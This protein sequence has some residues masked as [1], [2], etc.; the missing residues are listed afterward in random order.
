[1]IKIEEIEGFSVI[2]SSE[3]LSNNEL[4]KELL[5]AY[6]FDIG[7]EGVEDLDESYFIE[8]EEDSDENTKSGLKIFFANRSESI[9]DLNLFKEKIITDIMLFL[10]A[11]L[12]FL[13]EEGINHEITDIEKQNWRENWKENFQPMVYDKFL[14]LPIWLKDNENIENKIKILI[15]PKMAFGTGTHETTGLMLDMIGSLDLEDKVVFDAGTGSGILAI[16]SVKVGAI[17]VEAVDIDIESIDNTKENCVYNEV[18]EKVNVSFTSDESYQDKESFDI[19]LANINRKV[20]L[21]LFE[22]FFNITKRDGFIILSG[23]LIEEKKHIISRID[24]YIDLKIV[25]YKE[26]NEWCSFKISKLL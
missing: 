18:E 4:N 3:E 2:I 6:A 22:G 1:M 17:K 26:K 25:D 7:S 16:A 14:V 23:I 9:E 21:D 12:K 10:K 20:L 13:N 15:E 19:V 5:T 8:G 11:G 24:S